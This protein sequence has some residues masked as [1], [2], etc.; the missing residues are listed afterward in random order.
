MT[1]ILGAMQAP[2]DNSVSQLVPWLIM[3]LI[4]LVIV[5]LLV[6][7]RYGKLRRI[8]AAALPHLWTD[9]VLRYFPGVVEHFRSLAPDHIRRHVEAQRRQA[10]RM[11]RERGRRN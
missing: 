5:L 1:A 4:V 9:D 3:G 7:S 8:V 11:Q 10:R 6:W 2:A